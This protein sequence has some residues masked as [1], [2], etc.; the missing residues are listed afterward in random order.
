MSDQQ[1]TTQ[2]EAS[3]HTDDASLSAIP[4][5]M[6]V[7]CDGTSCRIVRRPKRQ[8][9][10]FFTADAATEVKSPAN[11]VDNSTTLAPTPPTA[12]APPPPPTAA[13]AATPPKVEDAKL[14]DEDILKEG[15]NRFV[16]FPIRYPALYALYKKALASFWTVEEVDLAQDMK[17]WEG[18]TPSEQYFIK[19]VLA[20]FAAADGIVIENLAL[21]F[22]SDVQASEAKCFYAAQIQQEA[23]HSET[24]S[25]LL[26]TFVKDPKEKTEL[27]N[28]IKTMAA[29]KAKADWALKW[30]ASKQSFAERLVAFAAVEMIM[31]SGS[32]CA[33]YWL[34]KRGKMPGLTF[35]NEKIAADEQLHCTFAVTLFHL[36]R[37]KPQESVIHDIVKSALDAERQFVCESLPV[38][39]IGINATTMTQYIEFVADFLL[40]QLGY[41]KVYNVQ[42][43][44]DWMDMISMSGK[45]NFF[46]KRVGEYQR[47]HRTSTNTN[48]T[49]GSVTN[50]A[51]TATSSNPHQTGATDKP[52]V[53]ELDW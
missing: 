49:S 15:E 42:N 17:D 14:N 43:P 27:F 10:F 8:A 24:Y 44:F 4:D 46:E 31:F 3:K 23:I 5:G 50:V 18:M 26:D 33:L 38:G 34:K 29:V 36:L 6:E 37:N 47:A 45:T 40:D 32:F 19:H 52:F 53:T 21:R 22:M 7:V 9:Q 30:M 2:K 39:L 28:A 11:V 13:A 20:F 16:L 1:N 12:A 48:T 41:Q 35:S 25:I 51:L